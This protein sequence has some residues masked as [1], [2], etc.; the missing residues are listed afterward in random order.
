VLHSG[1]RGIGNQLAKQHIECA[2]GLMKQYFIT[3][4]DPDLAYLVEGTAEFERYIAA[5]LWAQ[6]Y[7]SQNR[8]VMLGLAHGAVT[9]VLG[10]DVAVV[11]RVNCHHNFTTKEH[12]HGADV[13]VTRKGA[14][15]ARQGVRGVIPGSMGTRSYIVSGLGNPASFESSSHGAGRS[16]SRAKARKTLDRAG[17]EAAMAGKAWNHDA[18]HLIDEDP[19]AY[20]DIDA[21]MAA[22]AD[23]TTIEHQLHQVLN[24][25][26][27]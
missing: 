19:R 1:S 24:Y 17:L 20:K 10:R 22:Q 27:T 5:M 23:L 25:K 15:L 14:I 7:A 2:K 3:L 9:T 18:E 11:D 16:M 4:D 12:H 8:E 21:V 26:G 6:D 13:W